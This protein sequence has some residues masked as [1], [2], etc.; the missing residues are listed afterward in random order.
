ISD[1]MLDQLSQVAS[2]LA[3]E[4]VEIERDLF[5]EVVPSDRVVGEVTPAGA[6]LSGL[7]AGIP[8][9]ASGVD[10][11]IA[12]LASGGRA[13]GDNTLMMGT[14]WCLG[15]LS[16]KEGH[17]PVGGM[18]HMPHV[19]H[20]ENLAFSMTGGSYTGGTAGFWMPE[21][22]TKASFE[23]LEREANMVP[24]GSSGVVFLPYLMGDRTPLVRHEVSG[25][26]IGLRAEH[27]RGHMFRAVME[28]GA[29]Q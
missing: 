13:S 26:F 25:A 17:G 8:V 22:V 2:K 18:V 1:V 9:V 21:M 14:S 12:L 28:G 20:G 4:K 16:K 10:G 6:G 7:E 27:N 24:P 11:A 29:M 19:L 5:G 15:M 23:D 3:G